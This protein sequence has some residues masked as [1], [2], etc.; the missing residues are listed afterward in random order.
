MSSSHPQSVIPSNATVQYED[1]SKKKPSWKM[2]AREYQLRKQNDPLIN[3][4]TKQKRETLVDTN[5]HVFSHMAKNSEL[6]LNP[7]KSLNQ[8]ALV[9]AVMKPY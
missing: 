2:R 3:F 4:G 1:M 6:E 5:K 9:E 7:E 8:V